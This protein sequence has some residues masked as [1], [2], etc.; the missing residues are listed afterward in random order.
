MTRYSITEQEIGQ[1]AL[2]HAYAFETIEALVRAADRGNAKA[3]SR[4]AEMRA[5][6]AAD[7]AAFE[8]AVEALK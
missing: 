7:K 6:V 3:A 8:A 2:T 5:N 1:I 4:L